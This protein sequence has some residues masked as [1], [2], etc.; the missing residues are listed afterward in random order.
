MRTTI[1]ADTRNVGTGKRGH[2]AI[3]SDAAHSVRVLSENEEIP[4][5]V[6]DDA[7]WR[8]EISR[9]W[10]AIRQPLL[11]GPVDC[12]VVR[13]VDVAADVHRCQSAVG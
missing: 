13:K 12:P 6:H 8:A 3:R 7:V 9:P 10:R 11:C 2:R 1:A 5:A 4:G